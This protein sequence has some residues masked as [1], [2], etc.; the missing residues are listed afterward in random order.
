[1]TK[2]GVWNCLCCIQVIIILKLEERGINPWRDNGVICDKDTVLVSMAGV[3]TLCKSRAKDAGPGIGS[4]FWQDSPLPATVDEDY[5]LQ[6]P[7]GV[8]FTVRTFDGQPL[9]VG[10]QFYLT[11]DE[12]FL[13]Y[14]VE[15]DAAVLKDVDAGEDPVELDDL[16]R[17]CIHGTEQGLQVTPPSTIDSRPA[18]S[19]SDS[20]SNGHVNSTVS[21]LSDL[22]KPIL[23]KKSQS[24]ARLAV[25]A[26]KVTDIPRSQSDSALHKE[27]SSA[28]RID[29]VR[30][31][32]SLV[33]QIPERDLTEIDAPSHKP[34]SVGMVLEEDGANDEFD[35]IRGTDVDDGEYTLQF[36]DVSLGMILKRDKRRG[37][38]LVTSLVDNSEAELFGVEVSSCN[39]ESFH[40]HGAHT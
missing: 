24:S 12:G 37:I 5:I 8:R 19:V 31:D 9:H 39:Y 33:A 36:G 2:C 30:L 6:Q 35:E 17:F 25:L 38:V 34:F 21:A 32:Q 40:G 23:F 20:T 13:R 22:G 29:R 26:P 10:G 11:D 3:M 15:R 7:Q 27:D 28:P 18:S 1:M 4:V 16:I 14:D